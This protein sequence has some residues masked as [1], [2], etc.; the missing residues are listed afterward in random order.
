[1]LR[2]TDFVHW[3][4]GVI[5]GALAND[6]F[7]PFTEVRLTVLDDGELTLLYGPA[8]HRKSREERTFISTHSVGIRDCKGGCFG[9]FEFFLPP[10]VAMLFD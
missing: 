8:V 10:P 2:M 7:P 4:T 1:M 6:R 3:R 9:V 5:H